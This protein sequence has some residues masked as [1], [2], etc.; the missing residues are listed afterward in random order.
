MANNVNAIIEE[1][2]KGMTGNIQ[3]DAVYLEDQ[4]LK[5]RDDENAEE[6]LG[7]ISDIAFDMMPEDKKAYLRETM[8]IGDKRLDQVFNDANELFKEGKLEESAELMKKIEEKADIY[9]KNPENSNNFSFRNRFDE[10]L[11][12]ELFKPEKN[13]YRTPYDICMYLNA[14]GYVLVELGRAEE[15]E[16]VLEKAI[17]FNPV[18]I[19]P[20]FELT[21]SYKL[22]KLPAKLLAS[23]KE[24]LPIASS[25]EEIARC[26]CDLG[27]YCI[28]IKDYDSAVA[29][30]YASM[31]YARNEN[32]IG[33]IQHIAMLKGKQVEPPTKSDIENAFK[34]YHIKEGANPVVI[35][36]AY[37]LGEYC[38]EHN[39]HPQE[40]LYYY[41]IAYNLTRDEEIKKKLD[42][43]VEQAKELAQKQQNGNK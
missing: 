34:K 4:M 9:A 38:V 25:P 14:Y 41:S 40:S 13:F 24:T 29:F 27:Y 39:A 19:G 37:S 7:K 16:A 10:Y 33:E 6:I 20:R 31:L 43:L 42:K 8:F 12:R 28:E 18:N 3:E 15:A 36:M 23:V 1:I 30:Y 32:V 5:Y 11:Y 17:R 26:Y 2:K 35:N 21:E 22:R